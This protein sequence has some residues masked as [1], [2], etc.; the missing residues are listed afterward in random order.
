MNL[1]ISC[2]GADAP[3]EEESSDEY[4]SYYYY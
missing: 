4:Y 1:E 3:A 2:I